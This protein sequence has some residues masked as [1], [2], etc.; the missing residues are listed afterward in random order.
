[1]VKWP[2]RCTKP[3]AAS[4]PL[5]VR[6]SGAH[7]QC[8]PG[9]TSNKNWP[10]GEIRNAPNPPTDF[11]SKPIT[12]RA[13]DMRHAQDQPHPHIRANHP[14][15]LTDA[16]GRRNW[17]LGE[18]RRR[19]RPP[20]TDR[21]TRRWHG[22]P[23]PSR[24]AKEPPKSLVPGV[25]ELATWRIFAADNPGR[26][27]PPADPLLPIPAGSNTECDLTEHRRRCSS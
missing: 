21:A 15:P 23:V 2:I 18:I 1:V 19:T 9:P 25:P 27:R 7:S 10:L 3:Q 20:R 8:R 13:L 24:P 17:P 6:T 26:L 22:L 16:H 4:G 11:V 5:T 12:A 14:T